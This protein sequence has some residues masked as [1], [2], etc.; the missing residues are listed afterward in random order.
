MHLAHRVFE[1]TAEAG[2]G[3]PTAGGQ[4]PLVLLIDA[5]CYRWIMVEWRG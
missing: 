5:C 1:P 3:T 4:R 2:S